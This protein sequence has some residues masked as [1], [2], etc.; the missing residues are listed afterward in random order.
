[1]KPAEFLLLLLGA[2]LLLTSRANGD[3]CPA[4]EQAVQLFLSGSPDDYIS[5]MGRYV[6]DPAVLANEAALKKCVD[7]KLTEEDKQHAMSAVNKLFSS[8]LC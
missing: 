6:S 3:I 2:A 8:T 1:M 7:S 5:N 4:V